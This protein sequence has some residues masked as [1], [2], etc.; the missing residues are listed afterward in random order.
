MSEEM[1]SYNRPACVSLLVCSTLFVLSIFDIPWLSSMVKFSVWQ[2]IQGLL[3]TFP[4]QW[5]TLTRQQCLE[6]SASCPGKSPIP[7]VCPTTRAW[8]PQWAPG[9]HA[10]KS[11]HFTSFSRVWGLSLYQIPEKA[12]DALDHQHEKQRVLKVK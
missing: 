10:P 3:W 5:G 9:Y 8:G 1:P 4:W 2:G 11:H 12:C 7:Q 6:E